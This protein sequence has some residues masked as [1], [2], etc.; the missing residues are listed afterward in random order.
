MSLRKR[1]FMLGGVT[2]LPV[3]AIQAY[4]EFDIRRARKSEVRASVVL[5]AERLAASQQRL[6]RRAGYSTSCSDAAGNEIVTANPESLCTAI[7][8]LIC[9]TSERTSP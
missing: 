1:L 6:C 3:V 5:Q 7:V 4:N 9:W 8:P 2:L